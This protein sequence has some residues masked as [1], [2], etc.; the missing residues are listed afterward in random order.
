MP[1][2]LL[3]KIIRAKLT[4]SWVV[5]GLGYATSIRVQL[6]VGPC[7][8]YARRTPNHHESFFNNTRNQPS[9]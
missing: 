7:Q 2:L 9:S 8:R 6:I 4:F 5:S 3:P 1:L